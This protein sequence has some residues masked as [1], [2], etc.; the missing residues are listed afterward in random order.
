MS[1]LSTSRRLAGCTP[2]LSVGHL[3]KMSFHPPDMKRFP[4]IELGYR[5]VHSGATAGAV[6][7]AAN[8]ALVEAFLQRRIRLTDIPI[9]AETVLDHH[10]LIS[11]PDLADILAAADWA[12][13]EVRKCI[14]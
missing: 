2:R 14:A 9:L 5:V 12:V 13:N 10:E 4:A 11:E 8:E 7:N 3:A 6:L 1:L